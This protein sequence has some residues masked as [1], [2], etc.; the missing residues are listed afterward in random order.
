MGKGKTKYLLALLPFL[1]LV[2]MYELLPLFTVVMDSVKSDTTG[3]FTWENYQTIFSKLLYQKALINSL[4]IS[5]KSSLIG[6]AV[7]F[8]GA[9]AAHAAQ[10]KLQSLFMAVLNMVSNFAGV[11][12][13][14]AYMILLGNAGVLTQIGRQ[15]GIAALADFDLYTTSGIT[16]VYVYFQIPL[17]T[18][19]LFP[20]FYG[21]QKEWKEAASLL[22][23]NKLQFW[24]RV[25][26]PVLMPQIM[27]TISILF[28]NALAA[29]ATVYALMMSSMA[30]LPVQISGCFVGES[31]MQKGLGGAL[32]VV[33]MLIMVVAIL[34]FHAIGNHFQKGERKA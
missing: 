13:A 10:G 32:S 18:L 9:Q 26:T 1:F 28:A 17:A 4:K 3:G 11:P 12:L 16:M 20:A 15:Y 30:L 27:N 14:F 29:Y 33:M 7:A 8:L 31:K 22:G 23:A 24:T 5:L 2:F 19:L 25:G 21:I 34:V 6:I